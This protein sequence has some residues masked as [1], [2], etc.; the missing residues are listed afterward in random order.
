M[1]NLISAIEQH[2]NTDIT[3]QNYVPKVLEKQ[4]EIPRINL[5]SV[6]DG[7]DEKEHHHGRSNI[8]L[9]I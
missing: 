1:F 8:S 9:K 7:P 4:N 2:V 5:T 3:E 6:H